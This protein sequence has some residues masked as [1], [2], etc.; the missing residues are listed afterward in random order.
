M[1]T[2]RPLFVSLL[3][4]WYWHAFLWNGVLYR[5]GQGRQT[6]KCVSFSLLAEWCVLKLSCC[7]CCCMLLPCAVLCSW[8][9]HYWCWMNPPTT[10]TSMLSSGWT[11]EVGRKR[12]MKWESTGIGWGREGE[13][14][15]C[16]V[17]G[18]LAVLCKK[19]SKKD[20]ESEVVQRK[21]AG[22]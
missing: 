7:C 3:T 22:G 10:W 11:G 20:C 16:I 8:S 18:R 21:Q 4:F 12:W 19:K 13:C 6:R 9:L 17:H 5:R 14:R 2:N 1:P 15:V